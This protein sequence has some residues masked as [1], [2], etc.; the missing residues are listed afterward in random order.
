[1]NGQEDGRAGATSGGDGLS[2]TQRE[3]IRADEVRADEERRY[4]E[5]VRRD[6]RREG[7]GDSMWDRIVAVLKLEPAIF[8]AVAADTSATWQAVGVFALAT[9]VG[10][11][12]TAFVIPVFGVLLIPLIVVS[13][14]IGVLVHTLVVRLLSMLFADSLPPYSAWLRAMLYTVPPTAF[15]VIPMVG[16]F[17]SPVYVFVLQVVAIR[18]VARISTG[19]ALVVLLLPWAVLG[20]LVALFGMALV[21]A[22]L[23]EATS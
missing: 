6:I 2:D 19:K 12:L 23:G 15:N 11:L 9:V 10:S 5:S 17:V 1:M 20:L 16:W 7:R 22:L 8:E 4:R 18:Q 3:R 13:A 21:V 14:F